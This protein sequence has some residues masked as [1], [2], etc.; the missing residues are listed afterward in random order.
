MGQPKLRSLVRH[1]VIWLHNVRTLLLQ[2]T[3]QKQRD[4][5]AVQKGQNVSIWFYS[6]E[7]FCQ[8]GN[9]YWE[10]FEEKI[11]EDQFGWTYQIVLKKKWE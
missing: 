9:G 8:F 3:F 11:D 5:L 1:L 4:G 6:K 10:M 7:I 2:T